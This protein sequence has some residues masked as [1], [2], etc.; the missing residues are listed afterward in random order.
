MSRDTE[1]KQLAVLALSSSNTLFERVRSGSSSLAVELTGLRATLNTIIRRI[2]ATTV[3]YLS[4]VR[5]TLQRCRNACLEFQEVLDRSGDDQRD[6]SEL[7][8]KYL[9]YDENGFGQLL[10]RYK[11]IINIALAIEALQVSESSLYFTNSDHSL[12][13]I[14]SLQCETSNII[15]TFPMRLKTT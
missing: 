4:S 7:D 1:L 6:F 8:L 3:V 9:G 5:P 10:A 13:Q 15:K 12:V 11:S 2:R 14:P